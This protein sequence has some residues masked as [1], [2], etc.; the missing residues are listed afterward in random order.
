MAP[1]TTSIVEQVCSIWSFMRQ[2]ARDQSG[3]SAF[4]SKRVD[5]LEKDASTI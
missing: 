1:T 5:L 2:I 3:A 4:T